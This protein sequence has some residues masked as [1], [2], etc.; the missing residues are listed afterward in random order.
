MHWP[1]A[2]LT[3]GSY[4]CYRVGQGAFSGLE[5]ER[6]G[7]LLFAGEHTSIDFQ[8]YLEGA[9]ESGLRAANELLADLG[10]AEIPVPEAE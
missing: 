1:S 8:G 5:G 2:P 3:R 9:A 7:N 4:A 10:K 6:A